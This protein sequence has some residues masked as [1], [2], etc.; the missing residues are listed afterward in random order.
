MEEESNRS[1]AILCSFIGGLIGTIPWILIYVYGNM[2]VAIL[3]IFIAM[4]AWKGYNLAKGKTD[5]YVPTII[6]IVSIASV[7]IAT[8]II[9]PALLLLKEG[10]HVS[11]SAIKDLYEYSS[12]T[13]GIL[14]D[15]LISLLFTGLGISGV[16]TNMK[17]QIRTGKKI[18]LMDYTNISEEEKEIMHKV[19]NKYG[20]FDKYNTISQKEI[21]DG[22]DDE[23]KEILFM[24]FTSN[25]IIKHYK[26]KYYYNEEI[27]K[28]PGKANLKR[29][30][31]I[32]LWIVLI[33]ITISV[34]TAILTSNNNN[35]NNNINNNEIP[36]ERIEYNEV[37]QDDT[38]SY[39]VPDSWIEIEKYR[40]DNIYYYTPTIDKTG[41]SGIIS[42]RYGDTDYSIDDFNGFKSAIK[43]TYENDPD[44][45]VI[46]T[47]INEFKNELG[48]RVVEIIM[49]LADETYPTTEYMYYIHGDNIYGLVYLT[50]Y[51][52]KYV[53]EPKKIAYSMVEQFNFI[54]GESNNE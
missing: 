42:V 1:L 22:I 20:A 27:A 50:D 17:N 25:G 46:S 18:N 44:E 29:T 36:N 52:S 15:Y 5:K 12:F 3:A 24:K 34:I 37:I 39:L 8:F 35:N 48:Y 13:S 41:Y 30:M 6:V 28:N 2:I 47:N 23:N 16:I 10:G 31:K 26:G 33:M 19:F 32:V 38:I 9:I 51:H 11:I 7:T 49:E 43:E 14:R 54:E 53:K 4:A 45:N 40:K 21:L